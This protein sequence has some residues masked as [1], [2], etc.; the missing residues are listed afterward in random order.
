MK[1]K[2]VLL[3]TFGSLI[4]AGL[5]AL[6]L[7]IV[8]HAAGKATV[9]AT[10]GVNIRKS[11]S[12]SSVIVASANKNDI[13][14]VISSETG[15]DGQV[16]YKVQVDANTTGYVR[17]DLVTVDGNVSSGNSGS[18]G[19]STTTTTPTVSPTV[20]VETEAVSGTATQDVNV[21]EGASTNHKVLD[22]VKKNTAV[23]VTGYAN[24]SGGQKWYRVTYTSNSK[25]V[26]GYIRS[27]YVKLNA[28]LVEKKEEP[29]PEPE[30]E[31]QPEP[32]PEPEP[33]PVYKDYE[34]VYSP[35]EETWYLNNYPAGVKY[36]ISELEA[37][38][39]EINKLKKA[40]K[41]AIG[42]KNFVIG[43]LIFIILL[44]VGAGVYAFLRFR[45][46]YFGYDDETETPVT[47]SSSSRDSRVYSG[48][49]PSS[50]AGRSSSEIRTQTVGSE[51]KPETSAV[52]PT[53]PVTHTVSAGTQSHPAGT[54]SSSLPEGSVR[55]ADGRIKLPDGTIKRAVV[56]VKLP[57]GSIKLPDGR[58]RKP[59]GTIVKPVSEDT[60]TILSRTANSSHEVHEVK[61]SKGI[62]DDDMEFGFLKFNGDK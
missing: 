36:K 9:T 17:G 53:A 55:L 1:I 61:G 30:P 57:D 42:K 58:I 59:D 41:S 14:D 38:N 35:E 10:D 16:W 54:P 19:G 48:T 47:R 40:N 26:V 31:P 12:V 20:P 11:A 3:N 24:V 50:S 7:P 15:A 29:E 13:L 5:L 39:E 43:L 25:Q 4:A 21:R 62:D 32:E 52:K 27:D 60:D 34:A 44:L 49:K 8:A 22:T 51:K 23:T 18:Q 2:A 33:E 28:D 6:L 37:A 56:G 45:K 46:W